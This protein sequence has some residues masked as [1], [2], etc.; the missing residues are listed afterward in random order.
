MSYEILA[1]S[2]VLSEPQFLCLYNGD[3][4]PYLT[5]QEVCDE[6]RRLG[7]TMCVQVLKNP[8]KL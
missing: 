3:K 6:M 5:G 4:N 1:W 8:N 7:E 2:P